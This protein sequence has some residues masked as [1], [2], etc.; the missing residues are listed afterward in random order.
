MQ[1]QRFFLQMILWQCVLSEL[2]QTLL[3]VVNRD[4]GKEKQGGF[5]FVC[6][7]QQA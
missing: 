1:T 5:Y 7:V 3:T 4:E 6:R 2:E